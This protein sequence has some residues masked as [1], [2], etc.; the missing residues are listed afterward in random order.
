M[1]MPEPALRVLVVD[2]EAPARTRLKSFL[3]EDPEVELVGECGNGEQAVEWILRERPDVVFLDI[4]MPRLGGFGVFERVPAEAMPLVVFTTAFSEYAVRAFEVHA[5]DYLLKPFDRER[6]RQTLARVRQVRGAADPDALRT[7]VQQVLEAVREGAGRSERLA[8][9]VDGRL[10]FLRAEEIDWVEAEGN[11]VKIHAGP[12]VHLVRETMAWCE[13]QLPPG[14]FLR[15]SRSAI[16]NVDRVREV[17]PLFS[18]DQLVLMRDGMK[19]TLSRTHR[20]RLERMLGR[21]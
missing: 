11:Y 7:A 12:A 13:Q 8:V 19:L 9:K 15:I 21:E 6:F 18:G 3:R 14:R 20:E 1:P 2:D 5:V 10:V 4:R 16:V 17:Q